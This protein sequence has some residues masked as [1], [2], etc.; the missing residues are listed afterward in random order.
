MK[1]KLLKLLKS[2]FGR[3]LVIQTGVKLLATALGLYTTSWLIA[4]TT[5]AEYAEYSVVLSYVTIIQGMIVLGLPRLIQKFYTNNQDESLVANFWTTF[6]FFRIASYFL[7]LVL[8]LATFYLS[9]S[10]NLT[11]ILSLFTIQF[12]ILIDEAFRAICDSKGRTWQYSLTDFAERSTFVVALVIFSVTTLSNSINPLVYFIFVAFITRML[13]ILADAYWQRRFIRWGKLDW[14]VIL[15]NTNAIKYLAISGVM[16]SL[17][18][19]TKQIILSWYGA[20]DIVL[21][22]FFNANRLFT[23]AMI[24]PGMTIPMI[25]SLAKKNITRGKGY[26]LANWLKSKFNLSSS[27]SITFEFVVIIQIFSLLLALAIIILAPLGLYLID[28]EGKYPLG[29]STDYLRIMALGMLGYPASVFLANLLIFGHKEKYEFLSTFLVAIWG[30][31]AYF[32]LIYLG[33][34]YG[35]AWATVSIYLFDLLVKLLLTLR[36]NRLENRNQPESV[37]L[38]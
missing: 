5:T 3:S 30:L 33:M 28:P 36:M 29:L 35:A 24:V 37:N 2:R 38:G 18:S 10:T 21:G 17:F 23:V 1:T 13:M 27:L 19:Q 31:V 8:I 16:V 26:S 11:L 12:L 9:T 25:S 7:G 15:S 22:T 4:E 20:S 14:Q 34:G 6:V 32:W